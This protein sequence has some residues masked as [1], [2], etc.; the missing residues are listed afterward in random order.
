M[1]QDRPVIFGGSGSQEFAKKVTKYLDLNLGKANCDPFPNGERMVRISTDVRERDV[2]VILSTC[3]PNINDKLMELL[4][5][6]DA[7]K[8][9][10]VQRLTAVIPYFGYARQDRKAT[11]RTP[12]S[13]RLVCDLLEAAGFDRVLTMDLHAEQIQGFFSHGVLLDHLHAGEI[14]GERVTDLNLPDLVAL[15]PDLGNMKKLERYRM[16]WPEN[17][18]LAIIDKR[19]DA[20]GKVSS[21]MGV[22]GDIEG[23]N[24]LMAD[25]MI[26]TAGTMKLGIEIAI[27]KGAAPND[28]QGFYLFATH[29]EFVG[30]A[31]E[32]LRHPKIKEICVTDTITVSNEVMR[33]LPVKVLSVAPLFARAIHRIHTGDSISELLLP[34]GKH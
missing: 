16:W 25:D 22:I 29:G 32:N 1:K 26:S 11:G 23:K 31:I 30:K 14:I 7:L 12:I 3:P 21:V 13:A 20:R 19:R 18:D 2:F 17:I 10:N 5:W 34:R 27:E 8:R 24:V 33:E 28:D 4:I 6:G 9:A 15:S